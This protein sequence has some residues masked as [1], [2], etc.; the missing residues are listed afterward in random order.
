MLQICPMPILFPT[1]TLWLSLTLWWEKCTRRY[2]TPSQHKKTSFYC[3]IPFLWPHLRPKNSNM[4]LKIFFQTNHQSSLASLTECYKLV[5]QI[6]KDSFSSSSTIYGYFTNNPQA[7]N[8]LFYDLSTK[9]TIR[10]KQNQ[11]PTEAYVSMTPSLN[12]LQVF[13]LLD[14]QHRDTRNSWTRS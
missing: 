10:T 11:N 7:G 14:W 4:K 2:Q 5:T 6:S 13:S 12:S 3:Y 9:E 8:F 1:P